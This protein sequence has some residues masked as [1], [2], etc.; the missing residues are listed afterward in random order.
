LAQIL[1]N[2]TGFGFWIAWA[3][4]I[5]IIALTVAVARLSDGQIA[6]VSV[7]RNLVADII[8]DGHSAD[9]LISLGDQSGS[10]GVRG[11][12]IAARRRNQ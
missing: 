8:D 6:P 2:M 5:D 9:V 12:V 10:G 3:T 11:G 1:T 7:D 4:A